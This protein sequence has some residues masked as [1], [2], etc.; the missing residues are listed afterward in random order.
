MPIPSHESINVRSEKQTASS[1]IWNR[2][3]DS[4]S[5]NDNRYTVQL[6]KALSLKLAMCRICLREEV[7]IY[8][9]ITT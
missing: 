6:R 2:I 4:F 7:N 9:E 3:P 5:K 8:L 1:R